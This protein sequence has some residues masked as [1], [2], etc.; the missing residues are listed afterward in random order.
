M[1]D[2]WLIVGLGNP[3]EKYAGTRHNAGFIVL[4]SIVNLLGCENLKA[5]GKGHL[6][7]VKIENKNCILLKP[8]TFMNKS[9]D[10]I[11]EV[12]SFFKIPLNHIIILCD[13]TN[14]KTGQIKIREKGSSGGH[15]GVL[16]VI[17]KFRTENFIRIKIGVNDKPSVRYDLKNWV[18]T[19][20]NKKELEEVLLSSKDVL[21][22]IKLIVNNNIDKAMNLFNKKEKID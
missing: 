21:E 1:Q 9:A 20:F 3:G 18:L 12:V 7:N 11:L 19:K 15:K 10:S 6:T 8:M 5:Q 2:K 22:A 16:S 13:D 4:D 17:E 14:F